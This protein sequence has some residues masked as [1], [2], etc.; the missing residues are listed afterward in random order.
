[1][2]NLLQSNICAPF[3]Q[4]LVIFQG[5]H[6]VQ[7]FRL[8]CHRDFDKPLSRRVDPRSKQTSGCR[9]LHRAAES[10]GRAKRPLVLPR[11]SRER[12]QVLVP[13][14][15]NTD[16]VAATLTR[17]GLAALIFVVL[18]SRRGLCD[19]KQCS[20]RRPDWRHA[21]DTPGIEGQRGRTEATA[22]GERQVGIEGLRVARSD[23]PRFAVS[24]LPA[25]ARA[26][27]RRSAPQCRSRCSGV[28][29]K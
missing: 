14:A 12:P 15:A 5:E 3:Y 24:R 2:Y 25:L 29:T 7:A 28:P 17:C 4:D 27:V 11:R 21:R 6:H 18:L 10:D 20:A 9:Q 23:G 13:A 19:R 16:H 26:A 8:M 22:S 1:M